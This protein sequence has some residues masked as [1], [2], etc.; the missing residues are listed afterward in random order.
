MKWIPVFINEKYFEIIT[1][2]MTFCQK[3]KGLKI[4]AYVIMDNHFHMVVSN[5]NL[6]NVISSLKKFSAKRIIDELKNDRKYWLLNQLKYYKLRHKKQSEHQVWQE[7]FHP[8]EIISEDMLARIIDYIHYNPVKR[9]YVD[10]PEHWKY[11]SAGFYMDGRQ[12]IVKIDD[13]ELM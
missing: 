12:G 4:F 13:I 7:G 6:S 8:K 10:E 1:D 5:I 3:N 9:G 11:S 2:S